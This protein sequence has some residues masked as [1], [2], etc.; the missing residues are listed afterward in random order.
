M[1]M[2]TFEIRLEGG[3]ANNF[4]YSKNGKEG[5]VSIWKHGSSFIITFEECNKGDQ[6]NEAGYTRD[7]RHEFSNLKKAIEFLLENNFSPTEFTH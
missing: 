1:K 2:E 3:K 5:L 6:F 4:I 7:E